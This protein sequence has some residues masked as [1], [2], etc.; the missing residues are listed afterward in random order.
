MIIPKGFEKLS[1]QFKILIANAALSYQIFDLMPIPME[2]FAP[3]GVCIYINRAG[4]E[5]S[6]VPD[7]GLIVGKY[8]ARTDPM[9]LKIVGQEILDR[10]FRGEVCEFKDFPVPVQDVIDRGISAEKP[11]ESATMDINILPVWD[12]ENFVC[13]ICFFTMRAVYQGRSDVAKACEYI[14]SH[15]MEDFD[16]EK[17]ARSVN[18]SPRHFR[19]IFTDVV[20]ETP[21]EFYQRIKIERLQEKLLDANL[22]VEKAFEEC[23]VDSHGSYYRLFKE[24]TGLTPSNFRKQKGLK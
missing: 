15:W 1:D 19:R 20:N 14:E 4:L 17:T 9:M 8:N 18:L 24:K 11:Y 22:S 21:L 13:T 23:G 3:D 6:G 12:G 7:A 16:L 2:V 10:A 5:M